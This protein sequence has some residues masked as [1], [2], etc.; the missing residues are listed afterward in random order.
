MGEKAGVIKIKELQKGV[1]SIMSVDM[2]HD[3]IRRFRTIKYEQIEEERPAETVLPCDKGYEPPTITE[4]RMVNAN[5]LSFFSHF[6]ISKGHGLTA[7]EV[8]A[9]IVDYVKA[10]NLQDPTNKAA[11]K[12]DPTLASIV[13]G[14][15]ENHV[16]ELSWDELTQRILNKMSDGYSVQFPGHPAEL[17][18]GKLE[19]VELT[20]ATR[21]GNKKITLVYNLET[22]GID[23]AEFAHKCQVGVAASSTV[24]PATNRKSGSE[25]LIQG[26]QVSFATRLLTT[27]Y[28]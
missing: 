8:R 10:N 20:I 19:P 5:V 2:E 11:V 25:V 4:L 23:P 13:L 6:R 26:N 27:D 1:E 24:N 17:H 7:K 18:K 9:H 14:R 28:K 12:L 15:G 22:Y 21:S 16:V 3:L